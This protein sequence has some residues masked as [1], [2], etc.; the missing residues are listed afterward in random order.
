MTKI[1]PYDVGHPARQKAI[2]IIEEVIEPLLG[3]GL[4]GVRY[5][6]VEDTLTEIIYSKHETLRNDNKR[7]GKQGTRG[8]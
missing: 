4:N 2:R 1:Q 7:K 5:Y 3:K 8:Q 6:E